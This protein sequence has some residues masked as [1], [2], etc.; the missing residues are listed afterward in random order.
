MVIASV[1]SMGMQD[2]HIYIIG[3]HL[4]NVTTSLIH[5]V[6]WT[7]LTAQHYAF[8]LRWDQKGLQLIHL[9]SLQTEI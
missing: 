4:Q 9:E 5:E 6:G 1:V 7:L 2:L 3:Y 8:C